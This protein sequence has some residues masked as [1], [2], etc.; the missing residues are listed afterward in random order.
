MA[1]SLEKAAIHSMEVTRIKEV[2]VLRS[3]VGKISLMMIY[4][5]CYS[6]D[7]KSHFTLMMGLKPS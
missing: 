5:I 7:I 1:N 6:D 2:P 3:S 4:S